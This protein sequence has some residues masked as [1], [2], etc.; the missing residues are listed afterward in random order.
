MTSL[1]PRP[2]DHLMLDQDLPDPS[3]AMRPSE[4]RRRR[5]GPRRARGRCRSGGG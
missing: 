2:V 3:T 5:L 1:D 4:R